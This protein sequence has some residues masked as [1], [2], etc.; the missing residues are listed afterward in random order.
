ML[1]RLNYELADH[2]VI[3]KR[4]PSFHLECLVYVVEDL[5]F[6]TRPVMAAVDGIAHSA[7]A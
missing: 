2:G 3:P 4:G 5:H 1:K 7:E 6:R